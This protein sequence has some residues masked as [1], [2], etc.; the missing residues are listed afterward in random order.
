LRII[1]HD[2]DHAR[3]Q[4]ALDR[5]I[6]AAFERAC[7]A[8]AATA[9]QHVDD[10]IDQIRVDGREAEIVEL[11]RAEHGNNCRQRN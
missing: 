5:R 4:H 7:R 8:A 10:R 9:E 3:D 1:Q 11:L 6:R 2:F